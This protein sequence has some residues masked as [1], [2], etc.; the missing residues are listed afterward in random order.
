MSNLAIYRKFRPKTFKDV[1]GQEMIVKILKEAASQD[2]LS[3]AYLFTGPRGT[4]KTTTARLIAKVANCQKR[5]TNKSF[6]EKGEPC[7]ECKACKNIDSGRCL[8]II[9][10]DAASNRGID[11]IRDLKEN[12]KVPPS[13]NPYK[14]FIIDEAHMLTKDAFNALLKTLEEPPEYIIIILATT[15]IEKI[16]S[17]ISSRTQQ[18]HFK[19]VPIQKVLE[20]LKGIIK[21][22]NIK[23]SDE[24]LELISSSSEGSFRDAESLLNQFIS[25]GDK[26]ITVEEIENMIGQVSF[27]KVDKISKLILEK[28]LDKTLEIISKINDNGY[29][30]AQFNKNLIKNLR[31]IAVLSLAPAMEKVFEKKLTK[32]HLEKIKKNA[33][34]FKK[35]DLKILKNLIEAY[36]QMRYSQFPII[37]LEIAIIESIKE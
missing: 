32:N 5:Q 28:D 13:S 27:D 34:I 16:P 18:F 29:N 30:L 35:E 31:Q 14:I 10:I 8:D 4:G 6:R 9:E 25:S 26:E 11:E 12:V 2:K 37:P 3:H 15:E 7:N 36:E 24:A 17:T 23:I 22:E 21:E 1:L 19:M 33:Q 20:K